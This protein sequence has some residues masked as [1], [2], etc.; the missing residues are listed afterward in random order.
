M[1]KMALR[2]CPGCGEYTLEDHCTRC[3]RSTER[4]GPARYSPEDRYG[5]YR[6]ALKREAGRPQEEE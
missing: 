4:A 6:R 2:R 5:R 3:G 1:S